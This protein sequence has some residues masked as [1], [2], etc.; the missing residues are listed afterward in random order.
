MLRAVFFTEYAALGKR[1]KVVMT[2][3]KQLS[4]AWRYGKKKKKVCVARNPEQKLSN[5]YL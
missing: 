1:A 2:I 4:A 5:G 3:G